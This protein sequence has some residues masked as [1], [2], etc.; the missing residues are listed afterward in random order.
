MLAIM[1]EFCADGRCLHDNLVG[2][3]PI[4]CRAKFF[5]HVK[6]WAQYLLGRFNSR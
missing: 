3:W 5:K 2:H 1:V 4:I 6:E